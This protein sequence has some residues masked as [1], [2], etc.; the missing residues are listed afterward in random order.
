MLRLILSVNLLAPR[1]LFP[2]LV[3]QDS[4]LILSC[5]LVASTRILIYTLL[6]TIRKRKITGFWNVLSDIQ[7]ST[8][9]LQF[10]LTFCPTHRYY[11][12]CDPTPLQSRPFYLNLSLSRKSSRY[13]FERQSALIAVFTLK[14]FLMVSFL[15][16]VEQVPRCMV[17]RRKFMSSRGLSV[18]IV[19][20]MMRF[21]QMA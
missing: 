18:L 15:H 9:T 17:F 20:S 7:Y 13:E 1:N 14:S 21:S 6:L 5:T 2:N 10:I 12:L 8:C 11:L 3:G 4:T 16:P 19:T